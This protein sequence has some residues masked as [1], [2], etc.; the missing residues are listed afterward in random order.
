[1]PWQVKSCSRT[2]R[3]PRRGRRRM[4]KGLRLPEQDSNRSGSREPAWARSNEDTFP[5]L[6]SSRPP[7]SPLGQPQR[8][9]K[10]H[11]TNH[12]GNTDGGDHVPEAQ[13][14]PPRPAARIELSLRHRQDSPCRRR[15]MDCHHRRSPHPLARPA[16]RDAILQSSAH[17][18][19]IDS[20]DHNIHKCWKP[21]VTV[22]HSRG[23]ERLA[24]RL[25]TTKAHRGDWRLPLSGESGL[26]PQARSGRWVKLL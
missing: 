1:M 22:T 23:I 19:R 8:R 18:V 4:L 9:G 15:D 21:E 17:H 16:E 5:P 3:T 12:S 10:R 25:L 7:P 13:R 14:W 20:M 6:G 2:G 24:S 26:G 11:Q